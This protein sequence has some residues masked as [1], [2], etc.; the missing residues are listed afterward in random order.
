MYNFLKIFKR[1]IF[2]Y[3]ID[4][5]YPKKVDVILLDYNYANLKF[6]HPI[7]YKVKK[8]NSIN[9]IALL[10]TIL[11]FILKFYKI[12]FADLYFKKYIEL[13]D[14]KVT[15]GH[16]IDR[17]IFR[18]KMLFPHKKSIVYQFAN[19]SNFFKN[20]AVK[21][22][23][24]NNKFELKSDYFLIKND[25]LKDFFDFVDAKFITVGSVKNNELIIKKAEKK[26]DIMFVS[27]Y[28]EP[29]PSYWGTNNNIGYM[30]TTLASISY[31][32]KILNSYSSERNKKICIAMCA[33]REDKSTK[34]N[35]EIDFYSRDIKNFY[36]ENTSSYDLAEKSEMVITIHSTLGSELLSRNK[37]ILFIDLL[38]FFG[39]AHAPFTNIKEDF[40]YYKGQ[41][42]VV[43]KEKIDQILQIKSDEWIKKLNESSF[44]MK[45]DQN[46]SILKQLV[47]DL[48]KNN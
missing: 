12:N 4:F 20:T 15:I 42:P 37:K 35:D 2:N 25:Y 8:K 47:K 40:F 41:D 18:F 34:L 48:I 45:F 9:L 27:Q 1:I 10:L 24:H 19:Y 46:N 33:Y 28:R 14:P 23:S 21:M 30:K 26:Y 6:A 3:S 11:S 43:I 17:S 29:T 5:E 44:K 31:L 36:H 7:S 16:E 22:M 38:H 13:H 32:M 39:S